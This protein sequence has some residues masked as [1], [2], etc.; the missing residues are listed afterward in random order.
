MEINVN[1]FLQLLMEENKRQNLV[2]RQTTFADLHLHV[3]DSLAA[4]QILPLAGQKIVDIGSGA[5][6]PGL[7]L[8]MAEPQCDMTL[9]ESD[10]KK[11]CF[12]KETIVALQL[13]NVKVIRT[14]V[15]MLGQDSQHRGA[16]D[17]CTSRAV[18]SMRILLEYGVPLVK[19]AGR[20]LM[21]K[22]SNYQQEISDAQTALETLGGRLAGIYPYALINDQDRAIVVVEKIHPTPPI[23]PR[24]VGAP[25]KRPL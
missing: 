23:Y 24:K 6:F 9:V 25:A 12:L 7:I 8:A 13:T 18:A 15:E 20:L 3:K 4:L 21:W 5:G 17:I 11:S 14:R 2:S 19:R 16:Y 22:G 1:R 10:L